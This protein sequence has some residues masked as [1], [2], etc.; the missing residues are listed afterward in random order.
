M[1]EYNVLSEF[2]M[3]LIPLLCKI[4]VHITNEF[5]KMQDQKYWVRSF[6]ATTY[7][8]TMLMRTLALLLI[9]QTG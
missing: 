9:L 3:V 8:L 4:A 6:M 1:N 7:K 2:G 5:K